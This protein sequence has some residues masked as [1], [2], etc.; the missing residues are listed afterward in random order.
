MTRRSGN[1]ITKELAVKIVRKLGA[2]EQSDPGDAHDNYVVYHDGREVASFGIRRSSQRN[3][4]HDHIPKELRVGTNFAKQLGQCPK[5]KK[6]YLD[7]LR[8]I[9]ELDPPEPQ[10]EAT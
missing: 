6:D 2:V 10:E 1:Q 7:H 9:G 4:G 5:S 3:K 8:S